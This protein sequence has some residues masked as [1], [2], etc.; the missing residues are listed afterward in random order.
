[1]EDAPNDD[2]DTDGR[3]QEEQTGTKDRE[4]KRNRNDSSDNK[5]GSGA[6]KESMSF[7]GKQE[8][9]DTIEVGAFYLSVQKEKKQSWADMVGEDEEKANSAPPMLNPIKTLSRLP[10][11]APRGVTDLDASDDSVAAEAFICRT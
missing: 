4:P 2:A 3:G 8:C 7:E 11:P 5:Q 6:A 9:L 10:V 1:M